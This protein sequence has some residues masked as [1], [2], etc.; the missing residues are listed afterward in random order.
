[1]ISGTDEPCF[2]DRREQIVG[3]IQT[4]WIECILLNIQIRLA[5]VAQSV[6]Q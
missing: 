2:E 1:M 5:L 4:S 6:K 3:K